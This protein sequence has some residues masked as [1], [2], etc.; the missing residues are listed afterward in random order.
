MNK[1]KEKMHKE[2]YIG[3]LKQMSSHKSF[4]SFIFK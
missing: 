1:E 4:A 2:V 3:S